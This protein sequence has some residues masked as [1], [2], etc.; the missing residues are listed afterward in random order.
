[1]EKALIN[2]AAK[3]SRRRVLLQGIACATMSGAI[4]TANTNAALANKLPQSAVSYRTKPNGSKK[5]SNCALF[6][7]PHA[8]KN[9]AGNIS[10]DGYCLLWRAK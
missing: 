8:C 9:V 7:P 1:M 6:E 4:L 2:S 5:C 3:V 10:P